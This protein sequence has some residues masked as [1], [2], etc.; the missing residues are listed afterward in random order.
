MP[1]LTSILASL[2]CLVAVTAAQGK[3]PNGWEDRAYRPPSKLWNIYPDAPDL[4]KER[5]SFHVETWNN[6]S[7]VEQVLLF[8]GIPSNAQDCRVDWRQGDRLSRVF[9][10]EGNDALTRVRQ[11][12][13]FP[14]PRYVTYNSIKPFD[15]AKK[16]IGAAE[17]TGWQDIAEPGQIIDHIV[18][19][20]KCNKTLR[21]KA[22]LRNP[23]G[24]TKLILDQNRENGVQISYTCKR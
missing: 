16:D 6:A 12:S 19:G 13:G 7:Q 15:T 2:A 23:N 24:D 9:I 18:G 5:K 11:L 8:T 17:F 10:L 22:K 20:I 3:C 1:S 21:L 14:D 4:Y